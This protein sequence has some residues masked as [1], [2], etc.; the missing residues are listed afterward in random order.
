MGFRTE[1]GLV[2]MTV[3]LLGGLGQDPT[4]EAQRPRAPP[5]RPPRGRQEGWG[6]GQGQ[7]SGLQQWN[8]PPCHPL[9]PCPGGRPNPKPLTGL[10]QSFPRRSAL[11]TPGRATR[12]AD[13]LS[14]E[15]GGGPTAPS[16][17]SVRQ[18]GATHNASPATV[19]TCCSRALLWAGGSGFPCG[20]P[21]PLG[22]T[23]L[24]AE[25]GGA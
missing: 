9:Q 22:T 5:S 1:L 19:P 3:A 17:S 2:W 16:G 25:L 14:I 11:A 6:R 23:S 13:V 21:R 4:Q 8:A 7:S 12:K 10:P 15:P 24:V 18:A 20:G